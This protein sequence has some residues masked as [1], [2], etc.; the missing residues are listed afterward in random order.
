MLYFF[1]NASQTLAPRTPYVA[2]YGG[3]PSAI[4]ILPAIGATNVLQRFLFQPN[5]SDYP[6]DS[7]SLEIA[8]EDNT[9]LSV[10]NLTFYWLPRL[11]GVSSDLR[12]KGWTWDPNTQGNAIVRN[13]T[14]YG[15]VYTVSEISWIFV[16]TRA[17][18]VAVQVLLPPIFVLVSV[19]ISFIM[20]ITASI[21]RIGI[22]GSALISEVSLHNGFKAANGTVG[23]M[24]VISSYLFPN[25]KSFILI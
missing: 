23:T 6:F 11:S 2:N 1:D 22:V 8:L 16:V 18:I 20:P 17:K 15:G 3:T 21:T 12:L 9:G 24:Y 10:Q 13:R 4:T 19:L 25:S 7:Q 14:Y 5:P